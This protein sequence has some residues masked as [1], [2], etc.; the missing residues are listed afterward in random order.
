MWDFWTIPSK[1][2]LFHGK[3]RPSNNWDNDWIEFY[4][5]PKESFSSE[6]E[7]FVVIISWL[8]SLSSKEM[9][10][11]VQYV[12]VGITIYH[13]CLM[14]CTTYLWWWLR[15]GLWHCYTIM[16]YYEIMFKRIF[17]HL[18]A[19]PWQVP[20]PCLWRH[21]HSDVRPLAATDRPSRS[22]EGAWKLP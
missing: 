13:P 22:T 10:S 1:W 9:P 17:W 19:R 15:A 14:V 21:L 8:K 12:H 16:R 6:G 5:F 11:S 3:H 20:W 18:S 7:H 2:G 4:W